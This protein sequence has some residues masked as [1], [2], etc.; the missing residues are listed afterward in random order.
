MGFRHLLCY[1]FPIAAV[2]Y[3]NRIAICLS[4]V[5]LFHCVAL[6]LRETGIIKGLEIVVQ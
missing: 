1:A 5:L 3:H 6:N 2:S 4:E